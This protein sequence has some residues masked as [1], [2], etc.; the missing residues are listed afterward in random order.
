[1]T[2][3]LLAEV[4]KTVHDAAFGYCS[5]NTQL[6]HKHVAALLADRNRLVE[7][8]EEMTDK[9]CSM[10]VSV[11]K[12]EETVSALEKEICQYKAA[13]ELSERE[14]RKLR[15]TVEKLTDNPSSG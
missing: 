11:N 14:I 15:D 2:P 1:M 12:M 3:E 6:Y 9:I 8:I 7:S 10:A 5:V 13:K 4:L